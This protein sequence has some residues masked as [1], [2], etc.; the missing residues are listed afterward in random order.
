MTQQAEATTSEEPNIDN[1]DDDQNQEGQR[2]ADQPS[3]GAPEG[4]ED[5]SVVVTFGEEPPPAA[6]DEQ[7]SAPEWVKELRKTN[8]EDKRRIRELE[9]QLKAKTATETKPVQVGDEPTLEHPDIDYDPDKFKAAYKQWHERKRQAEEQSAKAQAE[10]NAQQQAWEA[11]LNK[12]NE[13]KAKLKVDDFEDAEEF[14]RGTLST[15]QQGIIIKGSKNPEV[16]IY[17]LGRNHAKAKELAAITDPVEYAFAVA[18]LETKLK[19][20]PRK[21]PPPERTV[22]GSGRG[23]GAVDS[24][25]ERLRAEAEKTGDMNKLLQY[26]RQQRAKQS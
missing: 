13:D 7:A 11:K 19:V 4:G 10:A 6:E 9:E 3:D 20:T 24:T 26:K 8:R 25:L 21:A 15:V 22:S 17:A 14:V 16:L 18:Q 1:L 23:S 5:D 12:Y 2:D